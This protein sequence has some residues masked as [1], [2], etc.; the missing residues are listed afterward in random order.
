MKATITITIDG[1]NITVS[2]GSG[3]SGKARAPSGEVI[4]PG[5]SS[6][7]FPGKKGQAGL[8][9]GQAEMSDLVWWRDKIDADLGND[10]RSK[11]AD[12]NREDLAA[13][14]SEIDRRQNGGGDPGD[15]SHNGG[16][17]DDSIPFG[18]HTLP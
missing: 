12:K 10:P 11:F 15:F 7:P 14:R 16:S 3:G 6:R 2:T 8:T 9:V 4:P 18:P 5:G 13:L 1:D 17:N